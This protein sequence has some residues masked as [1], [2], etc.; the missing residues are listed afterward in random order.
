MNL[1]NELEEN[2]PTKSDEF[3]NIMHELDELVDQSGPASSEINIEEDE[4][5]N[6]IEEDE[7]QEEEFSEEDQENSIPDNK[8]YE[9]ESSEKP[10]KLKKPWKLEKT[11][12]KLKIEKIQAEKRIQ[13]LENLLTES[14]N[15]N[16]YHYGKNVYNDLE[17][18]K[19]Q[20]REAFKNG[21]MEGLI[22]SD[23][24]LYKAIN[25][26]NEL[27]KIADENKRVE[28]SRVS[29]PENN[30]NIYYEI[31][32]EWLEGQ[33]E[34]QRNSPQYNRQLAKT[35]NNFVNNLD[36]KLQQEDQMDMYYSPDYFEMIDDF[37]DD[38]K[39]RQQNTRP[40]SNLPL[41]SAHKDSYVGSVK[42]SYKGENIA[43]PVT[44]IKLT[45]EER[46]LCKAL[47]Q[48]EAEWIKFNIKEYTKGNKR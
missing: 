30:A 46:E 19:I 4:N 44:Q 39:T 42:N 47:G 12:Y 41:R 8:Q 35:V 10:R 38:V 1:E 45:A 22:E 32:Q 25:T 2:D 40:T 21:D 28:A 14:L 3:V 16:T 33:P 20:K 43:T 37:I 6:K 31:A 24:L 34:L 18:A 7:T 5:E 11:N 13:E 23:I 48:T 17:R 29:I 26:V 15:A 36:H 27:E 9:E